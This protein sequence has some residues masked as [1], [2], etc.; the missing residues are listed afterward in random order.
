[1]TW[2]NPAGCR[3]TALPTLVTWAGPPRP[4][5]GRRY[6]PRVL[7]APLRQPA[8]P[9]PG[10][11]A[12]AG[13]GRRP[14]HGRRPPHRR[15]GGA[16]GAGPAHPRTAG[17]DPAPLAVPGERR[18]HRRRRGR[19]AALAGGRRGG[20]PPRLGAAGHAA[21]RGAGAGSSRAV[22]SQ[23]RL[24][25][26]PAGQCGGRAARDRR[27]GRR[28]GRALRRRQGPD[29]RCRRARAVGRRRASRADRRRL[30]RHGRADGVAAGPAQGQR[31]LSRGPGQPAGRRP[32]PTAA[33][34]DALLRP[35]PPT[36]TSSTAARSAGWPLPGTGRTTRTG[37]GSRLVRSAVPVQD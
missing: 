17:R 4:R 28:G 22:A 13:R 32:A 26:R 21:G 27:V 29:R 35:R 19:D 16:G 5:R 12:P 2:M 31:H 1:M 8:R 7:A 9:D 36:W 18:P 30:R 23:P 33:G 6:C 20:R 37:S 24:P 25:A 11:R 3:S 34:D 15:G 14:A 10:R